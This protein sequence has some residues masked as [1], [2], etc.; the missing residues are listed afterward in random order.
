M[1]LKQYLLSNGITSLRGDKRYFLGRRIVH[2]YF[3]LHNNKP[4]KIKE[5]KYKVY[6]YHEEFLN[7]CNKIIVR[8]MKNPIDFTNKKCYK[9]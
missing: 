9:N 6:D 8:F 5:G 2:R 3:N 1:T 4:K 7:G